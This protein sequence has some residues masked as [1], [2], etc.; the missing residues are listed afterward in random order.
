VIQATYLSRG[1]A[2]PNAVNL[3][4]TPARP[5]DREAAWNE[6]V[7]PVT[8]FDLDDVTRAAEV[9]HGSSQDEFHA[10]TFLL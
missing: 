2:A 7:A 8:V 5:T 9:V 4:L 10:S 1:A 6:E 3:L